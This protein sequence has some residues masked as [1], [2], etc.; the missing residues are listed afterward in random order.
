MSKTNKV[1]RSTSKK[2]VVKKSNVN[3]KKVKKANEPKIELSA[4]TLKTIEALKNKGRKEIKTKEQLEKFPLGSLISFL[5]KSGK[6]SSGKKSSKKDGSGGKF[7][8][9]G[10]ICDYGEDYFIYITVDFENKYRV[11]YNRIIKMWVVD[12][13]KAGARE[14]ISFAFKKKTSYPVK[15]NGKVVYYATSEDT[16]KKFKKTPKYHVARKWVDKFSTG[17]DDEENSEEESQEE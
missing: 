4:T 16:A 3:R 13:N 7:K 12:V 5:K 8:K 11:K 10:F 1:T 9:G 17:D 2:T 6:K 14:A 15:L